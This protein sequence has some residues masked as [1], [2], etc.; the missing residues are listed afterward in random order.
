VNG[1][2]IFHAKITSL[3]GLN[4]GLENPFGITVFSDSLLSLDGLP[5]PP[6][7]AKVGVISANLSNI[8]ALRGVT[9]LRRLDLKGGVLTDV[10]ALASLEAVDTFLNVRGRLI[11]DASL[12]AFRRGTINVDCTAVCGEAPTPQPGC[13]VDLP[14]Y[15]GEGDDDF[16]LINFQGVTSMSKSGA[17]FPKLAPKSPLRVLIAATEDS[18]ADVTV[19]VE[20]ARQRLTSSTRFDVVVAPR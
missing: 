16:N 14:L 11:A 1:I 6:P 15:E 3:K 20:E 4:K 17:A 13:V 9:R 12:P 2:G 19:Q 8:D 10:N 18:V 7:G 5:P